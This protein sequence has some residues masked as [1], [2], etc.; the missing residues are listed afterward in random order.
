MLRIALSTLGTRKSGTLGA[1]AAV[2]LAV[3][4]VVSC[5]VLLDSSL[6]APIPRASA[7]VPRRWWFRPNPSIS[8]RGEVSVALRERPR[9]AASL[10]HRLRTVPGVRAAIADRVGLRSR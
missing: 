9:L 3:V 10:A 1:F 8:G 6:K 5:G 7:S 4:L 2:G